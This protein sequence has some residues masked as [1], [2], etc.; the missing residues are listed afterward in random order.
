MNEI[1]VEAF[2]SLIEY[3]HQGVNSGLLPEEAVNAFRFFMG[4]A[5][6][7]ET[8]QGWAYHKPHGYPG[9]FQ[10]IDYIYQGKCNSKPSYAKWDAYFQQCGAV[11]AVR[12]RKRFFVDLLS[13]LDKI[14]VGEVTRVLNV[15][16]GPG[17]DIAE[18]FSK[19]SLSSIHMD[20]VDQDSKAIEYARKLCKKHLDRVHFIERN[21]FRFQS[22]DTYDL[23]WSGGLFDYLSD[24]QFIYLL[25]HLMTFL[26]AEGELVIGNFS[27]MNP[28]RA[29]MEIV[30]DWH[31]NHRD[32]LH[33]TRLAKESGVHP[34]SIQVTAETKGINLFLH[35]RKNPEFVS[36]DECDVQILQKAF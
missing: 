27:P 23:I 32:E 18:Y 13:S 7:T 34:D 30:G 14:R 3:L 2:A 28:S 4:D 12:N 36:L 29:Y 8:L 22:D 25:K 21:A 6:S 33:L 5:L 10:M 24:K 31:L 26:R 1:R 16:S 19:A 11:L 17:R 15:A 35:V 20:C 9:D